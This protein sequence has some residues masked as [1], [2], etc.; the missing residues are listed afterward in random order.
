MSS[1]HLL[2]LHCG[3]HLMWYRHLVG[4]LVPLV[5]GVLPEP[6]YYWSREA[7]GLLNIVRQT[8]A[9]P[10]PAGYA[11]AAPQDLIQQGD[12]IAQPRGHSV[13]RAPT[14]QELGTSC[15]GHIVIRK[16]TP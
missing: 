16:A 10:T 11:P 2:I 6:G 5:E 15:Q 4:Q 12:F 8:D 13:W 3:D 9:A 1:T 14:L 7:S